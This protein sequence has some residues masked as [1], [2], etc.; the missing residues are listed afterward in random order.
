MKR[1]GFWVL[2]IVVVAVAMMAADRPATLTEN[3]QLRAGNLVLQIENTSTRMELLAL[4]HRQLQER[5]NE[6]A[7]EL[8]AL[9]AELLKT[10]NLDATK[11]FVDWTTLEVKPRAPAVAPATPASPEKETKP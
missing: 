5:Q 2:I 8:A 6:L 10:R 11:W 4:Q 9:G 7:K 3:E 1:C